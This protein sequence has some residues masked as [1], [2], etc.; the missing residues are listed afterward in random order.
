MLP[1]LAAPTEAAEAELEAKLCLF[2]R[3]DLIPSEPE[4]KS[5]RLPC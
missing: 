3:M 1:A 2:F 5:S 4:V